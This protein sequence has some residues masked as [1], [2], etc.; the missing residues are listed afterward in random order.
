MARTP[1]HDRLFRL[2]L[3]LFPSDFRGDFAENMRADFRDQHSEVDGRPNEVRRLWT[4]TIVDLL[5]QAPREHLDVLSRDV[6]YAVRVLRRHPLAS[7]TAILSL[8]IGIGLNSAVYS[9]VGNVLWRSLPIAESDRLVSIGM[10]TASSQRPDPVLVD[11]FLKLQARSHTFDGLAAGAIQMV[12][13]VEPGEPTQTG[14]LA[15]GP[16]FFD[17]FKVRPILGR[18]FSRADYDAVWA[19]RGAPNG[20]VPNP[21]VMLLSDSLWQ[22]RFGRDPNVV[23][24]SIRLAGG[25]RVAIAGVMG[26]EMEALGRVMPGQC[27]FPDV[28]DPAQGAWRPRIV[29]ARLAQDRTLDEANAELAVIGKGLGQDPFYKEQRTLRAVPVLDGIVGRVRTQ[30]IFLFGAVVCVLLV[31]CANVVN[32]F[33]AHAA[34]RRDELAMR[35]A[36]GASRSRL[37][38]QSVTESLLVSLLGGTCGFLLTLWAVPVLVSFAPRDLPRQQL[39]AVDWSTFV[40]ALGVSLAVGIGCGLL[41]SLPTTRV[42][43]IFG[44]VQAATTPRATRLRQAVTVCEIALALMLAVAAT[45]MVRTVQALNAIDL[46][47]DP[48]AVVAAELQFPFEELR[49]AQDVHMTV[50]ERVKAMPGVTTAGIGIGPLSGGM[51]VGGLTVPGD[52]REFPPVRVDAVSPGYF[53]AL[54]V[55]LLAGRFFESRDAVRDGRA[56]ILVNQTAARL[57]WRNADPLDKVLHLG[58]S[59]D[60]V[61]E[62]HVVGIIADLRGSTLEQQPEPAIYQLANQSRNFLAG[63]MLIRVDGDPQALVPQIRAVIRSLDRDTPFTGVTTL[64][65]RIDQAMAPRLFVLRVIGLFSILGLVLAVVGVYGVLAEFVVQRVPEIGVRMAFG[66]TARDVIAL[67]LGQGSRLVLLGLALGLGGAVLLRG[68]MS[69]LVYSVRTSDPLAYVTACVLLFAATVAA[70]AFP[71]RRASRLDPA[72]A[73]R[74]E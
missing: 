71:A 42:R 12:T 35:V 25:D 36:L 33:L 19:R 32:L 1:L 69:T 34:G 38:R 26:P 47:F 59:Q 53:E 44:V 52:T 54:G 41:A 7:A 11:Q 6:S 9:V 74:S 16:G 67:V 10:T 30:L 3:T 22:S 24:T 20:P 37:V 4:R 2:L 68:A 70:C 21:S 46:G 43:T 5:R 14:C 49:R 15:V 60:Q 63:T 56:V 58:F 57:F 62:M 51:F 48:S 45:L 40:F 18:G 61:T 13:I 23:G 31:T 64:Q 73:L 65:S 27:W 50:I 66:A 39:I 17:V 8:A 28:P 29:I 72:V 55:R